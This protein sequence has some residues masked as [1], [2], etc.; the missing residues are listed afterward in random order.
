MAWEG[1]NRTLAEIAKA[2]TEEALSQFEDRKKALLEGAEKAF[3]SDEDSTG[4]AAD[5]RALIKALV[6]RAESVVLDVRAPIDRARAAIV[7]AEERW[8][9]AL[10]TADEKIAGL[11][12]QYRK[13]ER[14]RIADRKR[15]QALEEAAA[16]AANNPLRIGA[17]RRAQ[18]E[19]TAGV[20]AAAGPTDLVPDAAVVEQAAPAMPDFEEPIVLPK[21]RGDY[22]SLTTDRAAA[23]FEI[24]DVRALPDEVL[25]APA[26]T[27]ALLSAIRAYHRLNPNVPGVKVGSTVKS[28]TRG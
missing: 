10:A 25:K 2:D 11:I 18:I 6:A 24:L 23:A 9:D 27:K 22:G 28:Q 13:D 19:S 26:V 20:E 3:V 14:Q 12:E 21:V 5:L 1:D 8:L 16:R 7:S 17:P 4:R 15:E